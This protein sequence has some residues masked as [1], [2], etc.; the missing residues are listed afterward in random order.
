MEPELKKFIN[1]FDYWVKQIRKEFN[2]FSD[3]PQIVDEL[4]DD[5]QHNCECIYELKEQLEELKQELNAIK[6][7]QIVSIRNK[8]KG[9]KYGRRTYP[10][11]S[12]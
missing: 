1:N 7:I 10:Q 9:D 5:T 12:K 6:L 2:E 4:V 11:T 3:I 8:V